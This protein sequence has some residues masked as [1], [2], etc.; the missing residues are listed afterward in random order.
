VREL[1]S[2]RGTLFVHLDRNVSQPIKLICDDIFGATQFVNDITWKRS[3]AHGDTGQG[4]THFGRVTESILVYAK[5]ETPIWEPQYVPYSDEIIQR[6]YKYLDNETGERYRLMP[7]DGP[8]GAAKGNPYYEFLG[9]K[10]Y[11]RYSEETMRDLHTKGEVV[12]S[13][14][15]KSLSRKRFLSPRRWRIAS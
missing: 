12:L 9:V 10:G 11:W 1:L 6:D 13:S 4:A 3:H 15:G 2:D 8:G 14:T 7:V 5:S